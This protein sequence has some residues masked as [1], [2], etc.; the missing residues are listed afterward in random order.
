MNL[1]KRSMQEVTSDLHTRKSVCVCVP[2]LLCMRTK[3]IFL[4][5]PQGFQSEGAE[6]TDDSLG[7]VSPLPRGESLQPRTHPP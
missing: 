7:I 5:V 6:E 3:T 2:G 1:A 4:L